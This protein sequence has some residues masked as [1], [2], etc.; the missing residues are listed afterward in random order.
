MSMPVKDPAKPDDASSTPQAPPL[1]G[2]PTDVKPPETKKKETEP[3]IP[4]GTSAAPATSPEEEKKPKTKKEKFNGFC[5]EVAKRLGEGSENN[6]YKD[7]DDKQMEK[8]F[9]E[10]GK[11]LGELIEFFKDKAEKKS[12][13]SKDMTPD[14]AKAEGLLI[15]I[16]GKD[17]E[18]QKGLKDILGGK[19]N[20]GQKADKFIGLLDE[21]GMLPADETK[22]KGLISAIKEGFAAFS[23]K[24]E[25]KVE[26]DS[27]VQV[28]PKT[29]PKNPADA[30]GQILGKKSDAQPQGPPSSS[31]ASTITSSTL[32]KKAQQQAAATTPTAAKKQTNAAVPTV[33]KGDPVKP[34]CKK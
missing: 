17:K 4:S 1:P 28:G 15:K 2:A 33:V 6:P 29:P 13:K 26:S 23:K 8:L 11:L 30:L 24:N 21:K 14:E 31:P 20:D 12:S 25:A 10:I 34:G 7:K 3:E 18:L 22:K 16:C 9:F 19:G 32:Q 27:T 5:N